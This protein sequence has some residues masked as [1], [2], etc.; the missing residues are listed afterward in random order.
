MRYD[1]QRRALHEEMKP[2]RPEHEGGLPQH[3]AERLAFDY[4]LVTWRDRVPAA[5][6]VG[7]C[8]HCGRRGEPSMPL[9]P[10]GALET[11]TIAQHTCCWSAWNVKRIRCGTAFLNSLGIK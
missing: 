2:H 1:A 11:G 5:L 4:T 9:V 7:I 10:Y 3:E 8:A 6:T